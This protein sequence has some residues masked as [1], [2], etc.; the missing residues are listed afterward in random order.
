MF[1]LHIG[2]STIPTP[3]QVSLPTFPKRI[4]EST[5]SELPS[6]VAECSSAKRRRRHEHYHS[7]HQIPRTQCMCPALAYP[8]A[9]SEVG[10]LL[11][12]DDP[13]PLPPSIRG[14]PFHPRSRWYSTTPSHQPIR[15]CNS[16]R[17]S[18]T[19]LIA[20]LL[21]GLELVRD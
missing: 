19:V 12:I 3:P 15:V 1:S 14:V 17:S 5:V 4:G 7:P 20:F 18:Y 9:G 10:S 11:T 16:T 6:H 8:D 2:L 13:R 21:P